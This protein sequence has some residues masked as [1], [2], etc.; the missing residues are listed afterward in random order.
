MIHKNNNPRVDIGTDLSIFKILQQQHY[1]IEIAL[2]EFVDNSIQS[3]IDYGDQLK[4]V[5]KEINIFIKDAGDEIII[6]D[7]AAGISIS[8][9]R[10]TMLPGLG[11]QS[12]DKQNFLSHY[13]IGLKAA[14]MWLS[15]TWRLETTR[16]GENNEI[17]LDVD[18]DKLIKSGDDSI[19]SDYVEGIPNGKHYTKIIIKDCLKRKFINI[20][21][22][23]NIILP[24][25]LET[26][27]RFN[28]IKISLYFE[29][30]RVLPNAKKLFLPGGDNLYPALEAPKFNKKHMPEGGLINWMKKIDFTLEN[31]RKRVSGNIWIMVKGSYRQPGIRLFR[32]DRVI[33]GTGAHRNLPEKI[34]GTMNK[35]GAQRIYG[36]L[37]LEGFAVN[38]QK[39]GFNENLD[40]VYDNLESILKKG[41]NLIDQANNYR[42]ST[43]IEEI[44]DKFFEKFNIK[45]SKTNYTKKESK[46]K[47]SNGIIRSEI[48]MDLT[49]RMESQKLYSLYNSL[50]KISLRT[51]A[52][53][54][55]IAACSFLEVLAKLMKEELIEKST[56]E[57]I[58]FLQ[59]KVK[60]KYSKE[61]SKTAIEFM[62]RIHYDANTSKHNP[63]Y[64][65]DNAIELRPMFAH[66]EEFIIWCLNEIIEK[67]KYKSH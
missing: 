60:L 31:G 34:T 48:I 28:D 4:N 25:L 6:Q 56:Q 17:K 54:M 21:N 29:D 18:L 12:T 41:H 37:D 16:I 1:P 15:N 9:I 62:R 39:N 58:N 2:A 49:Q 35:Y 46:D 45:I 13:G 53:L 10:K 11:S 59:N 3:F 38:Y 55:P 30:E 27:Y 40:L 44:D 67:Q 5:D 24:Y 50:C 64:T 51:N 43:S 36:E 8:N 7:N 66:L 20:E 61:K 65:S 19:V 52:I 23:K 26:F 22:C 32:N 33:I 14:A 63:T 42:V 57:A 47:L